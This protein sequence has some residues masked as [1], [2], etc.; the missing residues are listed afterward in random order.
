MPG[1]CR[2]KPVIALVSTT[3][4]HQLQYRPTQEASATVRNLNAED[5]EPAEGRFPDWPNPSDRAGTI[6]R[7]RKRN[8]LWRVRKGSA[9][10]PGP[11]L[12]LRFDL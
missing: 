2:V 6:E 1:A 10:I 4:S 11:S 12:P 3:G 9:K 8:R 7:L 5:P